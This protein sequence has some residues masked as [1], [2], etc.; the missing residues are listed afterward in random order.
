[1]GKHVAEK[2][3]TLRRVYLCVDEHLRDD[4]DFS[5]ALRENREAFILVPAEYT[6]RWH[7][8]ATVCIPTQNKKHKKNGAQPTLKNVAVHQDPMDLNP[9][10][11]VHLSGMAL[12]CDNLS[13]SVDLKIFPAARSSPCD[14]T[15]ELD[16]IVPALHSLVTA[17]K[18]QSQI[19]EFRFFY[20][21]SSHL[22]QFTS[23]RHSIA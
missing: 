21:I 4:E 6:Q 19:C 18:T 16:N 14:E 9:A 3:D 13:R 20:Q 23:G 1:M 17:A 5:R 10:P 7:D 2:W 11:V 15:E 22:S 12:S 8:L